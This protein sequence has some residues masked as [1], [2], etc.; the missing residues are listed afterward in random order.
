[1]GKKPYSLQ[2]RSGHVICPDSHLPRQSYAPPPVM[3]IRSGGDTRKF[4]LMLTA[5]I[6]SVSDMFVSDIAFID[7]RPHNSN[8]IGT[9]AQG[10]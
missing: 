2:L 7:G 3:S 4:D 9:V 6:W 10:E 8:G 5:G 1:M